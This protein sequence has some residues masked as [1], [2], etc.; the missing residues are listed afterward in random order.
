MKIKLDYTWVYIQREQHLF[1]HVSSRFLTALISLIS[2]PTSKISVG[3]HK[4]LHKNLY[5]KL[6]EM[7]PLRKMHC[8][9]FHALL[10]QENMQIGKWF[11]DLN[12]K[13]FFLLFF[14]FTKVFCWQRDLSATFLFCDVLKKGWKIDSRINLINESVRIKRTFYTRELPFAMNKKHFHFHVSRTDEEDSNCCVK[15]DE[16]HEF[17]MF[18]TQFYKIKKKN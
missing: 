14:C 10:F 6:C 15:W 18:V 2:I 9:N 1:W 4:I 13:V 3:A 16:M 11:Q 7:N 17:F 5:E 8:E 12:K